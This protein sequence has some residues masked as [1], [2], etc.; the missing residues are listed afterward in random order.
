MT[1]AFLYYMA[2]VFA[3]A[4]IAE[5]QAGGLV[6]LTPVSWAPR[7]P[8]LGIHPTVETLTAQGLLLALALAA[9]LWTFM[10]APRRAEAAERRRSGEAVA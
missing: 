4:G 6:P 2:F 3:G 9:L 1:S 7:V 8:A 10:L 5:L